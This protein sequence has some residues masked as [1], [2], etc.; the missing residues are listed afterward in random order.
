MIKAFWRTE[1]LNE[2]EDRLLSLVFFS[3]YNSSVRDNVSTCALRVAAAGNG[4]DFG[5]SV[6][7]AIMTFGGTH[8]PIEKIYGLLERND[9]TE[10]ASRLLWTGHR[11]PGWGH[12]FCKNGVDP[13]WR[14]T[15]EH[16]QEHFPVM[17]E[18]IGSITKVLHDNDRTVFIN[19]GGLTAASAILL[20]IPPH[21][22]S[23]LIIQGRL[24]AWAQLIAEM[25]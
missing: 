11:V 16:I 5:K 4:R 13:A 10:E 18:K 6:V 12:A 21:L 20:R 1:D 2:I 19:P 3:H 8:A 14:E 17:G 15:Y 25:Q 9:A 23:W 22:A 24:T 7:A